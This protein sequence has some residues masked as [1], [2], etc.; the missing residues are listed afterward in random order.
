MNT[1]I[2]QT[3]YPTI[4]VV[5]QINNLLEMLQNQVLIKAKENLSQ[6]TTE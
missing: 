1:V 4:Q 3:Q 2:N 5:C 6:L